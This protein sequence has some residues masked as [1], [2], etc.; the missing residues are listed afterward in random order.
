MKIIKASIV[1]SIAVLLGAPLTQAAKR[2][3][4]SDIIVMSP[5]VLPAPAQ[6][7]SEDFILHSDNAGNTYL[8]L[9]QQNGARLVILDV[10]DPA[11]IKLVASINTELRQ[12]YDFVQ[13][14][15]ST[16]E[17]IRF[18]DGSGIALVN[19]RKAKT[20][21]IINVGSLSA[22]PIEMLGVSGYLAVAQT[23]GIGAFNLHGHDVQVIDTEETPRLL[24]TVTHATREVSRPDTG[25][26]FLL[27][28]QGITV[29]R[30]TDVEQQYA[31]AE[32]S[33]RGN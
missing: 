7:P 16:S 25:T 1:L 15:G 33:K 29:I 20:P 17:L 32:A 9:E 10:T 18:R 26:L 12:A 14:I 27:G 28:D 23:A 13:S 3:P 8:Y 31:E 11:Q 22:E 6:N 19:F 5:T 2:T 4:K 30:R 24:A 21:R